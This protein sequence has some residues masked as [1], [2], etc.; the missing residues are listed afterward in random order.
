MTASF[1]S[2]ESLIAAASPPPDEMPAKMPSSRARRRVISSLSSWF[3]SITR[4]TRGRSKIF[5][6]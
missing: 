4:S 2:A 3:T 6:R 5:G 1:T